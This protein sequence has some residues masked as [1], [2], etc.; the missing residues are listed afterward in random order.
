MDFFEQQDSARRKTGLLI[1]YFIFA[2]SLI[3]VAVNTGSYFVLNISGYYSYTPETWLSGPMW[4]Y[5]TGTTVAV[6]VYGSLSRFISLS[7]G[8]QSVA[9]M[10]GARRL[11]LSSADPAEKTYINVTEEMSIASGIPMPQLYVMDQEHA[12]N[13]FVAG[14]KPTDTVLVVTKGTLGNL[15]RD[16]LQGVIGHEFSHILNGDMRINL[17]LIAI[18]AGI[19]SIGQ[20]GQFLFRI[21]FHTDDRDSGPGNTGL[22]SASLLIAI[23]A[24]LLVAIGYLGLFF[25]RLIKAA[26]SRQREFLAD[27]SAVQFTRNPR[28][29]SGALY[30]IGQNDGEAFLESRHA[31]DMSHMCFGETVH[32]NFR[33]L[34][35]THPPVDERIRAIDPAFLN[36]Q[37]AKRIVE[38][39]T[40]RKISEHA[41][42]FSGAEPV[43]TSSKEIVHSVGNVTP[44]HLIYAASI[45]K[46]FSDKLMGFVHSKEGAMAIIYALLLTG[47]DSSQ[48]LATLKPSAEMDLVNS[49]GDE[50]DVINELDPRQRFDLPPIKWTPGLWC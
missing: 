6:I 16:Q 48:E 34:L 29:I 31:E 30:K 45:H 22:G 27:A 42:G 44:E 36:I 43:H 47:E 12:I 46:T 18:L 37:R 26:I 33:G 13:A 19:L 24:I 50:L 40:Q 4:L 21:T 2:I 10:V 14:Y 28:G 3:V 23:P 39:R 25:G 7:S 32:M 5:A 9:N 8:G 11:D 38:K 1:L 41:M 17:R 35:A 15:D 20:L 49:L